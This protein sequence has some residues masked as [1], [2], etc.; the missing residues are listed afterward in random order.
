MSM[1]SKRYSIIFSSIALFV[2][3]VA[4]AFLPL[5]GLKETSGDFNHSYPLWMIIFG[6]HDSLTGIN[7]VPSIYLI[8]LY[9]LAILGSLIALMC[10]NSKSLI[11]LGALLA[12]AS[13]IDLCFTI[14]LMSLSTFLVTNNLSLGVGLILTIV[15]DFI[16][17]IL[18]IVSFTFVFIYDR[19]YAKK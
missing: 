18:L 6:G 9:F 17:L 4:L 16:V 10:Y 5:E 3:L 7:F 12:L 11:A 13:A 15:C 1:K 2:A 14:Q 8:P 19:K